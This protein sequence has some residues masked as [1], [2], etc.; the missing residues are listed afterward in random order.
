MDTFDDSPMHVIYRV[1]DGPL[2]WAEY[3]RWQVE[4]HRVGSEL[5]Y[6]AALAW[7]TEWGSNRHFGDVEFILVPDNLRGRGYATRLL[8][9]CRKKWQKV[10]LTVA[11][12]EGGEALDRI[13][14]ERPPCPDDCNLIFPEDMGGAYPEADRS[15]PSS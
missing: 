7:V 2:D 15:D 8:A 9:A 13:M 1:V 12:S 11:I 5:Q 4:L 10:V 6:P 3:N 14:M